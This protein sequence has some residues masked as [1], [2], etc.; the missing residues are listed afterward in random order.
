[1]YVVILSS[2]DLDYDQM[3]SKQN[4]NET[5]HMNSPSIMTQKIKQ[6]ADLMKDF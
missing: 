3:L 2:Q 6:M 4:D 5:P 1:M